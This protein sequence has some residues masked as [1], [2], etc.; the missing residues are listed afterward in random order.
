M[1]AKGK[2]DIAGLDAFA[3]K[4]VESRLFR[5]PLAEVLSDAGHGLHT[6]FEVV[7]CRIVC[8]DGLE[9]VGYT[10]TGGK[11]GSAIH[12]ML[13]DE[14]GPF[15]AGKDSTQVEALWEA[16]RSALHYLGLG[17][18]TAFAIAAAD[19]SLWDL[20][21]KRA[22]TPLWK[23]AGG[24]KDKVPCYRGLID[25]GYSDDYL[26]ERVSQEFAAGHTGIKLKVGR[27]DIDRDIARVKATRAQIGR[28][29]KLMADANYS[30]D[31]ASAIR[32]AHGVE[33]CD[34][35]WFEEPVPP[36]DMA[37]YAEVSRA[38]RIPIAS[39]ENWRT[40]TDFELG[41]AQAGVTYLQPDCSNIGGITGWLQVAKLAQEN[42]M[43][44]ASHGMHELHVSLMASQPNAAMLEVHSFPI[45]AYTKSPLK[46]ENGI[47]SAPQHPGIGVIF[48]DQLM[49]PHLSS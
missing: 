12:A 3:I 18:I 4:T 16:Q 46:I 8:R 43:P 25:L 2:T 47:A 41:I 11:G 33:D 31:A 19:I 35:S 7:T 23:I 6:H 32:F 29:A 49:A 17:G 45:D 36:D 38:T 13:R 14:I 22:D 30:W 20:R 48:D 37:A 44:I 24:H 15:L 40:L 1:P 39:G 21:C 9:G 34:L 10:Y 27:V 26:L 28:D 42:E 5:I